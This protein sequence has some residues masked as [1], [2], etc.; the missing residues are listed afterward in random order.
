[1]DIIDTADWGQ[2]DGFDISAVIVPDIESH[3]DEDW[4][5]MG[6]D[7]T[8]A[9]NRGDWSYVGVIVTA[10]RAGV[11]LGSDSIWG[12]EHGCI[13]GVAEFI[14]PLTDTDYPY[15]ADLISNAI[16]D[17]RMSISAINAV[18]TCADLGEIACGSEVCT[19]AS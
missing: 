6:A 14:N 11:A 2:V 12:S 10:S 16:A 8:A 15:R 4:R 17:A 5:S 13:P 1:M 19:C 7:S 9:Y 3:C 18:S